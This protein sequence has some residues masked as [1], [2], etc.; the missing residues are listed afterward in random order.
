M[1]H[2]H[3]D[4]SPKVYRQNPFK[5]SS[6]GI[7]GF[8]VLYLEHWEFL[9]EENWRRDP[10]WMGEFGSFFPDF[11]T[12][13]QREYGLRVGIFRVIEALEDAGIKPAI[14]ANSA[15]LKRLPNL[16]QRFNQMGC[17]W[18]GHG[19][20]INHMMHSKM[21]VEEQQKY[22]EDSLR[23]VEEFTGKT[24]K[25][26]VSQD[27]G[28]TT[29][30]PNLL[31]KLGIKY[32][33][34]WPNDEQPYILK[35][36]SATK[37]GAVLSIPM[38]NEYDDVQCQWFRNLN[39][40][41]F[42]TICTDGLSYLSREWQTKGVQSIYGLGLHP[43]L[44]GMPNRIKYLKQTLNELKNNKDVRWVSPEHILSEFTTHP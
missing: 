2:D 11:R 4:F 18:I 40:S 7:L 42:Q 21:S 41:E 1:D 30:T 17:E 28:S 34:D 35:N 29:Q 33:L 20:A 43:W 12:W 44:C 27:W 37:E 25:G 24:A 6:I 5:E 32:T 16:V 14:A 26:W 3:Y 31:S 36:K 22:I 39:A 10:R 19:V 13:T 23:A 9:P 8:V 15:A 38:S